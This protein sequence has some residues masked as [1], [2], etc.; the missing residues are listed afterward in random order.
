MKNFPDWTSI[1]DDPNNSDAKRETREYLRAA[2]RVHA[3][4]DLIDFVIDH[5]RGKRVLDIGIVSHS[6]DYFDRSDWRHKK[7]AESASYCLGI[8]II[9]SLIN[10]LAA[11]GYNVQCV[12]AT[13]D[14]FLG[15]L[16]DVVFIGDVIEHVVN[17][18]GLLSFAKRHINSTGKI[19]IST[20]NPF[21]RKFYK[22]FMKEGLV[23]TN[24]DH[25]GWI[26]PTNM[27]ELCRRTGTTLAAYHLIKK[28]SPLSAMIKKI[29]WQ[30]SPIEFSFP[31]Y[32]YEVRLDADCR[33][34]SCVGD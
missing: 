16:F 6:S 26:T 21:S 7:I 17:T 30:R 13:S 14:I 4:I 34:E 20:P 33:A 28:C 19:F 23:V 24:L 8:D 15:E 22:R 32:L 12:D 3:D 11:K 1:S 10:E 25:I 9:D 29:A 5:V 31:D 2:R 18:T 27:M